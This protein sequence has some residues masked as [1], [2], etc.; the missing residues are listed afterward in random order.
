M[1]FTKSLRGL[2]SYNTRNLKRIDFWDIQLYMTEPPNSSELEIV[3]VELT[4]WTK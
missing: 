4:H 1:I 3:S 2:W